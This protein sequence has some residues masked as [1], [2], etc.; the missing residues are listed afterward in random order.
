VR[1]EYAKALRGL[2][3]TR[4]RS[5][6]PA[7]R[8]VPAPR[9]HYAGGERVFVLDTDPRAWQVVVVAPS[10]KEHDAFDIEIGWSTRRRVPELGMRPSPGG[11]WSAE[12]IGRAEHLC[13]LSE[14][15]CDETAPPAAVDGG[16]W[17]ID[18]RTYS[19]NPDD[20][21]AALVERQTRMSADQ[22]RLV[23]APF[24]DDAM[25]VLVGQGLPYLETQLARLDG[26]RPPGDPGPD[27]GATRE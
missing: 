22:A 16:R 2:F 10:P 1:R 9:S 12:V 21:T 18:R 26:S 23:V 5:Q 8:A 15:I 7:W 20:I 27:Q 25:A 4:M 14:L 3:A 19:I 17:V 24:V 13:R 11:P 6:L